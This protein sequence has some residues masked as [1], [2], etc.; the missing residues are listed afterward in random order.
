MSGFTPAR[1]AVSIYANKKF[2]ELFGFQ[3]VDESLGQQTAGEARGYKVLEARNGRE[4]LQVAK[5]HQGPIHL[6]LTDVVMPKMSGRVL[7]EKMAIL[8]PE[9]KVLYVS[10]HTD[11]AV[12]RHGGL[13]AGSA[14]LEKPF[15]P[16]ALAR[17]FPKRWIGIPRRP[18]LIE[19]AASS[20]GILHVLGHAGFIQSR[21]FR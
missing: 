2:L 6:L 5:Q 11:D 19:A 8:R 14:L 10:G 16:D 4:A 7:A 17:K 15:T 18:G 3:S 1:G 20:A 12:N 21:P 13:N 9:L